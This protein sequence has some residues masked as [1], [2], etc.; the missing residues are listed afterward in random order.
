[1][2]KLLGAVLLLASAQAGAQFVDPAL[3]WRSF[4]TEHFTVHFAER[5]RS[6]ARAV[7]E[8]AESEV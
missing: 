2:R 4:D 3:P 1:M 7:A 6:Q 8:T 5:Y